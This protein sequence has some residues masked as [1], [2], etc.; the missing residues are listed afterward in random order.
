MDEAP[1]GRRSVSFSVP[2][3]PQPKQRSRTVRHR[4]TVH[5]YTPQE[6]IDA[7]N[8]IRLAYLSATGERRPP[9]EGPVELHLRAQYRIAKSWAKWRRERA[10]ENGWPAPQYADWDNLG[11]TVSDAL[12][13]VAY[14]DDRQVVSAHIEKR[15]GDRD[16]LQVKV[17][18]RKP[19]PQTMDEL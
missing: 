14:H 11:K 8:S 16:R 12:N 6:T 5:T 19:L 13:G 1:D 3:R 7:Q 2:G 15:Y 18:F 10:L 4:G 9:H 17:V